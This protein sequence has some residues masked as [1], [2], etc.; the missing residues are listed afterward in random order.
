MTKE[1]VVQNNQ[2]SLTRMKTQSLDLL[3]FHWWEYDDEGY[4]DALKYMAELKKEGKIKNL[5]LTNFDTN[6][7]SIIAKN[8]IRIVS[9][10]VSYSIIDLRPE[11]KM[12][13]FCKEH[14]IKLLT[15]GTILGGFF[16]EKYVGVP[17]PKSK[18]ELY[19]S[20][21]SKYKRF[22]DAW[23]GWNLFQ[24][25]LLVLKNIAE[26]YHVGI[27]NV[28]T[29]YILDKPQVAGVIV[30]TRLGISKHIEENQKTFSFK[31]TDDDIAKIHEISKAGKDLPGDCGD[32]YR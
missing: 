8:G 9:N 21:L 32:E 28:A 18:Q 16:S 23:G 6:H 25:L 10:Q 12:V 22:I 2:R 14:D 4:L 30:G 15:Y 13:P 3:Q 11:K 20:S 7:M 17:E 29:R 27:S 24:K 31:L 1:F 19:T 26:K 5:A